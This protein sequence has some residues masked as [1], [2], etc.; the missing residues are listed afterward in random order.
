[1]ASLGPREPSSL[2]GGLLS[3]D[4]VS[5]AA[6]MREMQACWERAMVEAESGGSVARLSLGLEVHDEFS[7]KLERKASIVP[8][9]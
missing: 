9:V 8:H 5:Q 4:Q 2:D 3:L 6:R 1:M 7:R